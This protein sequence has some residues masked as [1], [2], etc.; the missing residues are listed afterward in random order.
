VNRELSILVVDDEQNAIF[1]TE[2]ILREEGYEKIFHTSDSTTVL[3]MID[4]FAIDIVLLDITMPEVSGLELLPQIRDS[5]P[6]VSAIMITGH[7]DVEMSVDCMRSGAH[8]YIVKPVKNNRLLLSIDSTTRF[9]QIKRENELLK[10]QLLNPSKTANS[11]F[12]D[13]ITCSQSMLSLFQYCEAVSLS[14]QVILINGETGVGK[15]LFAKAIHT[16]SGCTG[17]FVAV[18]LA[19]VDAAVF[20]DTLFG[21]S[22]GAFTGADAARKGLIEKAEGGTLFLD[23][24][25]DLNE[26]AQVKLLRLLQEREYTPLG[27]DNQKYSTARIVTATHR[28]LKSLVKKGKFRSDL[29][30]RLKVHKFEIPPLRERKKDIA[31][32]LNHFIGQAA[33]ELGKS[34]P[35]YPPQLLSLLAT[36]SFPGNIR[37]FEAM[38]YNAVSRHHSKMLSMEIFKEAINDSL[39]L[40][41]SDSNLQTN[42]TRHSLSFPEKLPTL[43]EVSN[44]TVKEALMRSDNNQRIAAEM[45]GISHQ[46]I[47]K[48]IRNMNSNKS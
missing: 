27:S 42:S 21:H 39:E 31:L 36:Y 29:Y 24:I 38:I 5:F 28:N 16:L 17:K 12:S 7:D 35:S 14:R 3:E 37:E 6:L 26:D 20:S 25:G 8:D 4:E 15:E 2:A 43:K 9:Q 22:K 33:K 30:Y 10:Q 23:E 40:E 48:R 11:V 46:A 47:N 44:L 41:E 18:N 19:G 32:L 34:A 13:I 45:L 1:G